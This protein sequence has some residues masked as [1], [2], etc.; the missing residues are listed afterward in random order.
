M[1]LIA[2]G[3][4]LFLCGY[5]TAALAQDSSD[6]AK[7]IVPFVEKHCVKCHG[8]EKP[9][10]GLSLHTFKDAKGILK[11]RKLWDAA[12]HQI[13]SGEMPPAKQPQPTSTISS[14]TAAP[15]NFSSA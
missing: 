6:V 9:K 11:E 5:P 10:A 2:T 15:T 8:A 1:R 4:V 14:G 7:V 12:L 13:E 3:F